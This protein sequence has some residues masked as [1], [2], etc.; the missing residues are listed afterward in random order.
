MF[1][2]SAASRWLHRLALGNY[3]VARLT[4][5]ASGGRKSGASDATI[6]KVFVT[7]LARAGTTR[8]TQVLASLP[9]FRS[10]TYQDFPF[11]LMPDTWRRINTAG[12]K[13]DPVERKHGDGILVGYDSVEAIEEYFWKVVSND[14]YITEQ[15]LKFDTIDWTKLNLFGDYVSAVVRAGGPVE[16]PTYLS[17]NNNQIV[18]LEALHEALPEASFVVPIR[19]PVSHALSLFRQ[20]ERF[21]RLQTDDPFVLEFMDWLGHHEFGQH[22]KVFDL[23]KSDAFARIQTYPRS[24]PN[25]WMAVWINYHRYLADLAGLDRVVL[26]HFGSF[27]RYPSESMAALASEI[28][29]EWVGSLDPFTPAAPDIQNK[30]DSSLVA[31]AAELHAGL[32][33]KTINGPGNLTGIPSQI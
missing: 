30:L 6:K 15:T 9:G 17:K 29:F 26:F 18:R 11:P 8:L 5:K 27:C 7:G 16:D 23:G 2:Y 3:G 22:T 24:S 1:E 10:A 32:V 33:A 25:H 19:D 21:S 20:H 31:E 14:S 12:A 4:L 13:G 28:G